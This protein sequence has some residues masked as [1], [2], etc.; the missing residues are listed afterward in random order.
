[1][2]KAVMPSSSYDDRN[3]AFLPGGEA[4]R[5]WEAAAR[6]LRARSLLKR[7]SWQRLVTHLA[8]DRGLAWLVNG[9]AAKYG[10]EPTRL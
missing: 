1:M 7:C 9:L 8:K 4:R 5:Q 3:P 6:V 10:I 2:P